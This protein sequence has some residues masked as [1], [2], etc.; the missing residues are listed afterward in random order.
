VKYYKRNG[1]RYYLECHAAYAA[2]TQE[3]SA[4]GEIA[5]KPVTS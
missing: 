2:G 3:P 5:R 1:I 4:D